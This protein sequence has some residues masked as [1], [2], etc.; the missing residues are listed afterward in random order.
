MDDF[1]NLI[2][3]VANELPVIEGPIES[4]TGF[5]SLYRNGRIYLEKNNTNRKK[6][7]VLAEEYGH[8]KRTVGNILDYTAPGAWKEEWKARR[9][10]I[11]MLVTLDDLLNCALNG[12]NTKFECSEF[13]NVTVEFLED[14]LIHYFNKYGTNHYYRNYKFRFDT[15]SIF[16]E[17]L[18][19]YG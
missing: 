17:P 13:L 11:E 9:Y 19:I 15:E 6:K 18:N 14:A 10:G 16:V 12:C 2:A 8:Y 4:E 7:V 1:E 5:I 3:D